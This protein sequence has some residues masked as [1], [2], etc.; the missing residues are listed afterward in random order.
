MQDGP[1]AT[2]SPEAPTT[3]KSGGATRTAT[4]EAASGDAVER[5]VDKT[6]WYGGF[7]IT[8]DDVTATPEGGA[9][10][11]DLELS[12]ENLVGVKNTAPDTGYLEV[13]GGEVVE[14]T[15][16]NPDIAGFGKGT[17]AATASLKSTDD[18]ADLKETLDSLVLV[19][20]EPD[21]NTTRLPFAADAA[22]QTIEPRGI[23][24]GQT[25]GDKA[26][27]ELS[28]AFLWPSYEPG[29]KGKYELWTEVSVTCTDQCA[30]F[31]YGITI[32]NFTLTSP[33]GK[34]VKPDSRSPATMSSMSDISPVERQW[35][36]FVI[37][38]PTTGNYTFNLTMKA[39]SNQPEY[40]VDATTAITL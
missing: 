19:Y 24:V 14:V 29:E 12:Y 38:K 5:A 30:R 3:T 31:G 1:S 10:A 11:V 18:S 2:T 23:P 40:A 25:F 9:T 15:F 28:K 39:M 7:K 35:L 22:V 34:A 26:Q 21:S 37:D 32:A 27:I 4:T 36:V 33:T 17:G 16:D 13:D 20:G 8:V 6:G